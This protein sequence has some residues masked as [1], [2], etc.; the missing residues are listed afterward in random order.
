MHKH[1][2]PTSENTQ[3]G[4]IKKTSQL[5]LQRPLDNYMYRQFNIRKFYVLP[6]Q[7]LWISEQTAINSLH[8]SQVADLCSV[9]GKCSS[10]NRTLFCCSLQFQRPWHVLGGQSPAYHR[11]GMGSIPDQSMWDLWWTECHWDGFLCQYFSF[12]LSVSFHQCS[13]PIHSPTTHAF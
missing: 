12:P 6:T 10:R 5:T 4:S 1:S 2:K 8:N 13:I 3:P 9:D 11:G 7:C